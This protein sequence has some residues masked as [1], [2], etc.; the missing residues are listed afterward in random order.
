MTL[1]QTLDDLF[2]ADTVLQGLLATYKEQPA[3]FSIDP[4]PTAAEKPYIVSAGDL[5]AVPFDTKEQRGHEIYRDIRCYTAATGSAKTVDAIAK[6]VYDLLHR[7]P[8]VV[9]GMPVLLA[10]CTGPRKGP[11]EDAAYSRIVTLHIITQ[12]A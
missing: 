12:P 1:T 6:R 9:D 11:D 5:A 10:D 7:Q 3:F 4:P 8:L 2:K